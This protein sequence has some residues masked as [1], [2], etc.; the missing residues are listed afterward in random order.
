MLFSPLHTMCTST[1]IACE[2]TWMSSLRRKTVNHIY[3]LAVSHREDVSKRLLCCFTLL[4]QSGL[5]IFVTNLL[6]F[7]FFCLMNLYSLTARKTC[8]SST[9]NQFIE[10][11]GSG[12]QASVF[13]NSVSELI[14]KSF[15][16]KYKSSPTMNKH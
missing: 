16:I 12:L 8:Y 13:I 9:L 3:T 10:S 15:S 7:S 6:Y 5:A 11:Q 4:K 1:E 2:I 14:H